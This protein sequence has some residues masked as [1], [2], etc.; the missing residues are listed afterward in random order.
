MR[1][2]LDN[3]AYGRGKIDFGLLDRYTDRW[4]E[5]KTV[6]CSP[7]PLLEHFDSTLTEEPPG[8]SRTERIVQEFDPGSITVKVHMRGTG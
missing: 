4:Q 5:L 7:W 1:V 3:A 2:D 8:P 6:E